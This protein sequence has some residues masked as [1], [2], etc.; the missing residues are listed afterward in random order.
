MTGPDRTNRRLGGRTTADPLPVGARA[1]I[2]RCAS[3]LDEPRGTRARVSRLRGSIRPTARCG[4]RTSAQIHHAVGPDPAE[5]LSR[6]NHVLARRSAGGAGATVCGMFAAGVVAPRRARPGK[7]SEP[8][9]R[10]APSPRESFGVCPAPDRP[11]RPTTRQ[12]ERAL[13]RNEMIVFF[14]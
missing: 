8:R 1:V 9:Q 10:S 12:A 13:F 3:S 14:Y 6:R 5:G 4:L 2:S 11:C 7:R